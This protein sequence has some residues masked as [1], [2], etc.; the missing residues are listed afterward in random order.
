M[1]AYS[2]EHSA[3]VVRADLAAAHHKAWLRLGEPGTWLDAATRVAIAAQVRRAQTCALCKRIKAA[4]SPYAVT[5]THDAGD[6]LP[7]TWVDIVHRIVADPGRLTKGWFAR[8]VGTDIS[9]PEYVE[10]V[11]IVAQV[12]AIDTFARAIGSQPWSLPE[13]VAGA[14]SHYQPERAALR[15]AWVRTLAWDD[16]GP[17]EADFFDGPTGNIR[18]ALTLVPDEARSFWDIA[19]NQY[20]PIAAMRDWDNEYRAITHAQIELLAGRVSALNQCTY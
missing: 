1:P 20:L 12:T 6:E 3:F 9:E 4:V 17:R 15:T 10:L 14:P 5:G 2:K 11:A 8:T 16:H 18:T 19:F 13:P 7:A